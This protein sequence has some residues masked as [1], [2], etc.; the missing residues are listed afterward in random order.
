M[1]FTRIGCDESVVDWS[2]SKLVAASIEEPAVRYSDCRLA[3]PA[4]N[5]IGFELYPQV[6][7]YQANAPHKCFERVNPSAGG[8]WRDRL[9]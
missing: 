2:A 6:T 8:C 7:T 3:V 1:L 9:G 4:I 5:G